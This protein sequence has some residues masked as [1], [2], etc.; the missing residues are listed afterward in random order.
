MFYFR[1]KSFLL[2]PPAIYMNQVVQ[3]INCFR[4]LLFSID[5]ISLQNPARKLMK[6]R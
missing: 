4:I 5:P 6:M 2:L 3:K 1:L